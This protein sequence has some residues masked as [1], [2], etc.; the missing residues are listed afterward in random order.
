MLESLPDLLER[1]HRPLLQGGALA[2]F[3]IAGVVHPRV[4]GQK[5]LNSDLIK[6][7]INGVVLFAFSVVAI[8]VI[9]E[10]IHWGLLDLSGQSWWL[11][12]GVAFL[13]LDFARYWLHFMGHRVA[14]LWQFHRVHH[15]SEVLD[16]S[17]GLRMHLV[18]FI[19]LAIIPILLFNVVFQPMS[20]GVLETAMGVGI[21]F[22]CFQHSNLRWDVK[23]PVQ[24]AWHLLLNNPHFHSWHHTR[25]GVLCD[26][27]YSNT[28]IIWDRIFGT[29]VTRD[30]S[31]ALLGLEPDQQIQNTV[32]GW[33]LL[34]PVSAV[35]HERLDLS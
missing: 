11:Q 9:A 4:Q 18:D 10:Q 28:L 35:S 15:S 17:S 29:E 2:T 14:F 3:L 25:D 6:N 20:A 32:L 13:C 5:L 19:Q 33:Q 26:G 24:K 1:F 23:K 21:V 12:F 16:A 27:N 34:R 7:L 31:P 30:H 8:R 22:D